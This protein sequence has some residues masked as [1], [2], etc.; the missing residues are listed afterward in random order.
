MSARDTLERYEAEINKHDFDLLFPLISQDCTF[1]FSSGTFSGVEQARRAFE[2]TWGMIRDEIYSINE[3]HWIAESNRAAVCTY[4]F[5]WEGTIEGDRCKGN[6][7]GTSCFRKE[8]DRWRLI[9]EHLSPFPK[10]Q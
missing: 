2:K 5:H 7:R 3:V 8:G 9:H 1:W 4:T 6:G 10:E